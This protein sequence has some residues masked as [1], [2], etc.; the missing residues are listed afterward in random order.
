MPKSTKA[1]GE[2]SSAAKGSGAGAATAA[3]EQ[4]HCPEGSGDWSAHQRAGQAAQGALRSGHCARVWRGAVRPLHAPQAA[5]GQPERD[6]PEDAQVYEAGGGRAHAAGRHHGATAA[7]SG[8]AG[9]AGAGHTDRGVDHLC[10]GHSQ[11]APETRR[12][13]HQSRAGEAS[14]VCREGQGARLPEAAPGPLHSHVPEA[15][16]PG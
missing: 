6:L 5:A 2:G 14:M 15:A 1:T 12:F 13:S 10:R 9:A 16:L 3:A 8:P 4:N 11:A 7:G